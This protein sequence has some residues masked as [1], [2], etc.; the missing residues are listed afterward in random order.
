MFR[1]RI[2]MDPYSIFV[3]DPH[4]EYG[5][6]RTRSLDPDTYLLGILVLV[7][8]SGQLG[9]FQ[10]QSA[11]VG[12]WL[13]VLH[14]PSGLHYCRGRDSL[15]FL[16]KCLNWPVDIAILISSG[17]PFQLSQTRTEKKKKKFAL[18]SSLAL[19]FT[20][21]MRLAACLVC[22]GASAAI[23]NQL[24]RFTPSFPV[25]ILY[26]C[27]MSAWCLLSSSVVRPSSLNLV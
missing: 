5:S 25:S 2:R 8:P 19:G 20:M 10:R 27:T 1:I 11:V 14:S 15:Y 23:L 3:L 22:T 24:S 12:L 18:I 17:T 6:M 26:T 16:Y 7:S 13:L 4:L 9:P 21:F